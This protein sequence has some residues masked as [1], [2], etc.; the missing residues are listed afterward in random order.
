LVRS[1]TCAACFSCCLTFTNKTCCE[2][3]NEIRNERDL[4]LEALKESEW[5]M[6]DRVPM[7]LN[8]AFPQYTQAVSK[9]LMKILTWNNTI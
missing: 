6:V 1:V 9:M 2:T 3:L 4:L 7:T 5:T 8:R